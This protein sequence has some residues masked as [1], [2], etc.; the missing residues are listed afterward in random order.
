LIAGVH[1]NAAPSVEI[2][3]QLNKSLATG[4]LGCSPGTNPTIELSSL[5]SSI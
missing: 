1:K 3:P 2:R 5:F 4:R